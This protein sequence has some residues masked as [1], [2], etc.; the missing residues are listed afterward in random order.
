VTASVTTER[1]HLALLAFV[2]LKSSPAVLCVSAPSL[3]LCAKKKT[4]SAFSA[5]SKVK[6][7]LRKKFWIRIL[8]GDVNGIS[9]APAS[10]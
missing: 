5:R 1:P 7:S 2:S 4:P 6:K 10:Q 8:R 9:L 3:R